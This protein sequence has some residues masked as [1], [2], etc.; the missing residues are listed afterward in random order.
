VLAL[1]H[2]GCQYVRGLS[3]GSGV[4]LRVLQV[5][6][7]SYSSLLNLGWAVMLAQNWLCNQ[8]CQHLKQRMLTLADGLSFCS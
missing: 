1:V 5:C 8:Q 2:C 7:K 6:S 4:C 3:T